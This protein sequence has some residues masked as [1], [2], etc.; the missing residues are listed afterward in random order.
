MPEVNSQTATDPLDGL[1][2]TLDR[3][4]TAAF[5]QVT[6]GLSPVTVAQAFSD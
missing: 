3:A 6:F 4:T 2:E 1:S 5:A